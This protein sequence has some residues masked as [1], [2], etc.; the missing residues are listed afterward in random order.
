MLK[1]KSGEILIN[2][3]STGIVVRTFVKIL[4]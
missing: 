2:V 1:I 4:E 3:H